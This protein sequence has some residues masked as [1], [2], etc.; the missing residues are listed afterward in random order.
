MTYTTA[1]RPVTLNS[2][3]PSSAPE[4]L[5]DR[6]RCQS[7]L[8]G[9]PAP[10][11][12]KRRSTVVPPIGTGVAWQ[13]VER[14]VNEAAAAVVAA[15]ATASAILS[16]VE[17]E[18][19]DKSSPAMFA[20]FAAE[21]PFFMRWFADPAPFLTARWIWLRALGAIFFSAFYALWFQIHGLIGPGGTL[22][23][24]DYL[25]YAKQAVG[26]KAYW[27][28]PSLL[29]IDASR[30][31][32]TVIVAFGL[33]ASLAIVFNLWP[34][35]SIGVALI[36]FLSFVSA[37]QDFSGYQ[38]DGMLLEAAFLSLF[39]APRGLLP[40]FVAH[41]PPTRA[42][43]FLLQWEWFRIYFES[44]LVK[45]LSGEEQWRNL[46]AMDKYYENGPLP[47]WI[48]WH[49]Q[50]LPHAFHAATALATLIIELFIVWMLF[51]P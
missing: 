19:Y 44:G 35:L 43:V 38:S 3:R 14:E 1:P 16:M 41:D 28:I 29:W 24:R 11:P 33:A 18:E 45:I 34:R 15:N 39:L 2:T 8:S 25:L 50:H 20:E 40:K 49:V 31:A 10:Q 5:S 9:K 51:L 32:L 17:D 4:I 21:R 37:A 27:L 36:C 48:G 42:A 47:T 23:A 46:T 30:G 13:S 22:P 26:A 7:R 6:S 12:I